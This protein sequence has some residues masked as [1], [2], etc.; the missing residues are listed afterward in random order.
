MSVSIAATEH[1]TTIIR[2]VQRLHG[3]SHTIVQD[4]ES[5]FPAEREVSDETVEAVS[6]LL[7]CSP[8]PLSCHPDV[9]QVRK[10]YKAHACF[11]HLCGG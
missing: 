9:E 4:E 7:C 3:F 6:R 10:V 2:E 5:F 11:L 8:T 1:N